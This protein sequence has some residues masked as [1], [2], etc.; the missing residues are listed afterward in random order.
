MRSV[1]LGSPDWPF[2][3]LWLIDDLPPPD[4]KLTPPS[5]RFLGSFPWCWLGSGRRA[6][7]PTALG[8]GGAGSGVKGLTGL[9][10][11]IFLPR[12]H[13]RARWA[14]A[15]AMTVSRRPGVVRC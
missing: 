13:G 4:R 14:F 8:W 11:A 9:G 3:M 7:R 15:F 12:R 5:P 10:R 2:W 6:D 1:S